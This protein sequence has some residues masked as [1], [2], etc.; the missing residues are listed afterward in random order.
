MTR[1]ANKLT[2]FKVQKATKRGLYGDGLGLW[3]Q[4]GR[5]GTKSW[6]LR[7]M[8]NGK[9][10]YMG[11]GPVHSVSLPEARERCPGGAFCRCEG[12]GPAWR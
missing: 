7:Y 9:A 4:V 11:L 3:L 10:R 5:C 12:R 6:L 8:I 1:T 2:A